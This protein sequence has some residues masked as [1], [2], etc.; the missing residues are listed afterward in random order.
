MF[1]T[2]LIIPSLNPWNE[3]ECATCPAHVS[4]WSKTPTDSQNEPQTSAQ[5]VRSNTLCPP[6]G[7]DP[8]ACL[9]P[10]QAVRR[11][12]NR[13]YDGIPLPSTL[14]PN[15]TQKQSDRNAEI[16]RRY[17]DGESLLDLANEYGLSKQRIHQI[18]TGRDDVEGE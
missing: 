6:R 14:Q 5:Q 3:I 4:L 17:A 16:R 9:T 10:L 11:V 12:L 8:I 2:N 1:G 7:Y 13:L 18:A 15:K